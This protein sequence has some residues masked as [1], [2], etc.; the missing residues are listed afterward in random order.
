VG[1]VL[2]A[3]G[4]SL[5]LLANFG[6]LVVLSVS[7]RVLGVDAWLVGVVKRQAAEAGIGMPEVGVFDALRNA[8]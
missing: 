5:F 6:V 3:R 1:K 4:I 7:M 2:D 8:N